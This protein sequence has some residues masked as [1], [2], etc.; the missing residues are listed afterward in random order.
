MRSISGEVLPVKTDL[1]SIKERLVTGNHRFIGDHNHAG[2]IQTFRAILIRQV[3]ETTRC[4]RNSRQNQ[5]ALASFPPVPAD[6]RYRRPAV[7]RTKQLARERKAALSEPDIQFFKG[8]EHAI[9]S[10]EPDPSS[11]V[12]RVLFHDVFFPTQG[13]VAEVRI[14]QVVRADDGK[15]GIDRT[16]VAFVELIDSRFHVVVDAAKWHST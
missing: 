11:A 5:W 6:V 10:I 13:H 7:L 16:V 4:A 14:E 8:V 9:L 1:I 15:P 2:G 12:L 3:L